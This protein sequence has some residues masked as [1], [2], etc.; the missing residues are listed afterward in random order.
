MY[1]VKAKVCILKIKRKQSYVYEQTYDKDARFGYTLPNDVF[2]G[3]KAHIRMDKES[4]IITEAN[5]L[6]K[7][8]DGSPLAKFI[9]GDKSF[10]IPQ[11]HLLLN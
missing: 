11:N 10:D 8:L 2:Y 3:C 4:G 7:L 9:C 5:I 6:V 1:V